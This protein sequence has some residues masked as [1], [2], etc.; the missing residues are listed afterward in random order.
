MFVEREATCRERLGAE[1]V[2][3]VAEQVEEHERGRLVAF[4]AC[5]VGGA[6]EA[7][8]VLNLLWERPINEIEE[9]TRMLQR[10]GRSVE[11]MSERAKSDGSTDLSYRLLLRD[12]SRLDDLVKELQP[13]RGVSR[14]TALRA[15]DESE[16]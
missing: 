16:A 11:K 14:V 2:V 9:L 5:D 12:P 8:A 15:Q 4:G 7:D 10:H 6:G 1:V 13:L 3:A